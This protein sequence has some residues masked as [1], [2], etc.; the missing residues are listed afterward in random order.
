[1]ATDHTDGALPK[2]GSTSFVNIGWTMNKSEALRTIAAMN[3]ASSNRRDVVALGV[4][5]FSERSA[6]AIS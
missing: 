3:V 6:V 2:R 4:G 1:M 5:A